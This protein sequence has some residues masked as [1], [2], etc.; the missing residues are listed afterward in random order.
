MT[1]NRPQRHQLIR[2]WIGI[3]VTWSASCAVEILL[4]SEG[5]A[6]ALAATTT[7]ALFA[8]ALVTRRL[9]AHQGRA[10]IKV[11]D[12]RAARLRRR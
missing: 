5:V 11:S 8:G 7:A 10:N 3:G 12:L 6:L 9:T 2:A 1:L 4:L